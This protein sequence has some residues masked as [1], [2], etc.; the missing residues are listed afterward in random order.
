MASSS[1]S[2]ESPPSWATNGLRMQHAIQ[3]PKEQRELLV[4]EKSWA[5]NIRRDATGAPNVPVGVLENLRDLHRRGNGNPGSQPQVRRDSTHTEAQRPAKNLVRSRGTPK[6]TSQ[7]P[8]SPDSGSLTSWSESPTSHHR[9]GNILHQAPKDSSPTGPTVATRGRDLGH[10]STHSTPSHPQPLSAPTPKPVHNQDEPESDEEIQS[11]CSPQATISPTQPSSTPATKRR[12]RIPGFQDPEPFLSN[13]AG[14]ELLV[15]QPRVLPPHLDG[16]ARSTYQHTGNT[17]PSAQAIIPC[18]KD[19]PNQP[20]NKRPKLKQC[21]W[22]ARL[23]EF[24]SQNDETRLRLAQPRRNKDVASG[25][26]DSRTSSPSV[27]PATDRNNQSQHAQEIISRA[28]GLA[29]N[30]NDTTMSTSSNG[31]T[32]VTQVLPTSHDL[33]GPGSPAAGARVGQPATTSNQQNFDAA[34]TAMLPPTVS[35]SRTTPPAQVSPEWSTKSSDQPFLTFRAVYPDHK[36]SCHDFVR[37]CANLDELR[38]SK[39]LA[40]FLY[41][42]FIRVFSTEYLDYVFGCPESSKDILTA[43]EYYNDSCQRPLFQKGV[44][45]NK[46]LKRVL[47]EYP[48]EVTEIRAILKGDDPMSSPIKPSSLKPSAV[49]AVRRVPMTQDPLEGQAP[50]EP[51]FTQPPENVGDETVVPETTYRTSFASVDSDADMVD[52]FMPPPPPPLV[53][54]AE[55]EQL[56]VVSKTRVFQRA[57]TMRGAGVE[58]VRASIETGEANVTRGQPSPAQNRGGNTVPSRGSKAVSIMSALSVPRLSPTSSRRST[59]SGRVTRRMKDTKGKK[60]E[61]WKQFLI[62]KLERDSRKPES[63]APDSSMATKAT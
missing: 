12:R 27:I 45:T 10:N 34:R 28:V 39:R 56:V 16:I 20:A 29:A 25:I 18:T 6:Q 50:D 4:S 60:K 30:A 3:I 21:D 53:R 38:V 33:T 61:R 26:E 9:P 42:D 44:I 46:N 48:D 35:N 8:S 31:P 7:A 57:Q 41:D 36:G 40:S 14:S 43:V 1:K 55:G 63:I 47:G 13:E 11:Q 49:A 54:S 19:S 5:S 37:A 58:A 59:S 24:P 32:F 52:T 51:L 22:D 2:S 15:Q 23:K 17:P 62:N